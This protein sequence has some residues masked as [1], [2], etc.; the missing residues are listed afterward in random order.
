ME[1]PTTKAENVSVLIRAHKIVGDILV[2]TEG[3]TEVLKAVYN[4][5]RGILGET[6]KVSSPNAPDRSQKRTSRG[7][8]KGSREASNEP[9]E[10]KS[11]KAPSKKAQGGPKPGKQEASIPNSPSPPKSGRLTPTVDKEGVTRS[12]WKNRI[13]SSRQKCLEDWDSLNH[14]FH[15]RAA[16]I[17]CNAYKTLME[18]TE[19]YKA[20]GLSTPNEA[21]PFRNLPPT[22]LFLEIFSELEKSGWKTNDKSHFVIQTEEGKSLRGTQLFEKIKK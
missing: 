3:D 5:L 16:A 2:A 10:T 18:Q 22:S 7:R 1:T 12:T 4:Q 13:R 20:L 8:Q 15:E 6:Q 9:K 14:L 19:R 17:F 21:D 11:P